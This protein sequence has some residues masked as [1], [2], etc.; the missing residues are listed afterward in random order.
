ML[1]AQLL[2]FISSILWEVKSMILAFS[3]MVSAAILILIAGYFVSLWVYKLVLWIFKKFK[4]IKL[5]DKLDIEFPHEKEKWKEKET[6]SDKIQKR[7]KIDTAV[8]KACAY[9]VFLL[10]FRWA[11]VVLNITAVEEFM[12]DLIAYLPSLFVGILIWF[13]GI[14]FANFIYD[15]VY[16]TLNLTKQKAWKLIASGAK[17]VILFFTLMLVLDYTKI[18]DKTII[19]TILTGFIAMLT[20]AGWLAFWLGWKDV[21]RDIL[22]SLRK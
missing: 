16:H 9:Y 19:D 18:V 13:F 17:I 7:V 8:W 12:G 5:I 3:P 21:A 4:I 2:S 20:L 6:L 22:E 10:F 11:I 15:V 14:R 1:V